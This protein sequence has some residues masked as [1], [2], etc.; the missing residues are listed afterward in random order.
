MAS[1]AAQNSLR[2]TVVLALAAA[3]A[4][5]A[6]VGAQA[7]VVRG[8]NTGVL[9]YTG[10]SGEAN[11]LVASYPAPGTV[12]LIE[13]GRN[14]AF[15]VGMEPNDNCNGTALDVTC[16]GIRSLTIKSGDS[17]DY[18]DV[19]A[20]PL[21]ATVTTGNGNDQ[22]YTGSGDDNINSFGG[23]DL[24][25]GGLGSDV[26]TGGP[27]NDTV[28]Y[29]S[30]DAAQPVV[31]TL[32]GAQNDGCALCGERDRIGPDV[33][34]L[35]GGA[36]NDLL[37]G[38]AGANTI[39][40]GPGDDTLD[41]GAGDDVLLARDGSGDTVTCGSGSDGGSADPEDAIGPDCESITRASYDPGAPG[42]DGTGAPA[43]TGPGGERSTP[44]PLANLLPP[45]IPRQ[46]AAVS[47]SGVARVQIA[48]PADAGSCKGSLDLLLLDGAAVTGKAKATLARR[49]KLTKIG[50]A[51]FAARA[52]A[53]P[54]VQIRLNRRGRRRTL[55]ARHTHCRIVITTRA[56][57]GKTVRT[58][59]D[60]TLKPR[61]VVR[62]PRKPREPRRH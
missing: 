33:E 13:S 12:R 3:A 25:D 16:T 58:T 14:G 53:K 51:R 46:T 41:G 31:A 11:H 36:G 43:A 5:L 24:L 7:A 38:N 22:V 19:S 18:I 54:F 32:D 34:S 9:S 52:G 28:S 61:R 10:L 20:V 47:Q 50:H 1:E 42:S 6:P 39:A 48:C 59:R 17:G 23:D 8:A 62:K 15:P 29:A 26:Y 49:R 35:A 44:V 2:R 57:G 60:I 30:H 45:A 40:G 37:T 4:L 56:A 27:G 55:R 21:P